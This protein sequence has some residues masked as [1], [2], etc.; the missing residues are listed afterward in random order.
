M[1]RQSDNSRCSYNCRDWLNDHGHWNNTDNRK[2][3][4]RRDSGLEYEEQLNSE[5]NLSHSPSASGTTT[6]TYNATVENNQATQQGFQD[7]LDEIGKQLLNEFE[8]HAK[9]CTYCY[10]PLKTH[11]F[12]QNLCIKGCFYAHNVRKL[13]YESDAT[14][15][16][17]RQQNGSPIE[18]DFPSTK[19]HQFEDLLRAVE[20]QRTEHQVF[21]VLHCSTCQKSVKLGEQFDRYGQDTVLCSTCSFGLYFGYLRT[22]TGSSHLESNYEVFW[23]GS[24]IENTYCCA[25]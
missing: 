9:N 23:S 4:V 20:L 11:N 16:W 7:K 5:T 13:F 2:P 22:P 19:R 17:R 12:G 6:F 15:Y 25:Y 3:T 8:S 24:Q 14:F 10:N 21:G 18:F 1:I